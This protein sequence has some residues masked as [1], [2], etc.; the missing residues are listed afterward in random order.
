MITKLRENPALRERERER[1][2]ERDKLFFK[3]II[4]IGFH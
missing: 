3:L 4:C 1:E 2:R